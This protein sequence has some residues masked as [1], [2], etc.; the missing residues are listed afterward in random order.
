MKNSDVKIEGIP[1]ESLYDAPLKIE[2]LNLPPEKKVKLTLDGDLKSYG[3]CEAIYKSDKKGKIDLTEQEPVDGD[4]NGIKPMGLFQYRP[5]KKQ[6]EVEDN[7]SDRPFNS[8]D[9]E[10]SL[11]I[12]GDKIAKKEFK[13]VIKAEH[14]ERVEV[15]ENGLQGVLFKPTGDPPYPAV[16]ALGGSSGRCP[17]GIQTKLLTSR[18]YTVLALALFGT[19]DLPDELIGVPLEYYEKAVS[20][21]KSRNNIKNKPIGAMGGSKGGELALLLGSHIEDVQTVIAYSPSGVVFQGIPESF[22]SEFTSSWSY[23]NEP[24]DFVEF[25]FLPVIT[26]DLKRIFLRKP[27]SWEKAYTKAFNNNDNETIKKATIP[28]EKI[29]GPVL[30]VSGG[31]DKMWDAN[32]LSTIAVER[33]KNNNYSHSYKH[34]NFEKAGH[35]LTAPFT[36]V[37]GRDIVNNWKLGGKLQGFSKGDQKS[38]KYVLK[39][40]ERGLKNV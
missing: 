33:L 30:L 26:L 17:T 25:S 9:F 27:I 37:T 16:I 2:I 1:K 18:G 11:E 28:V 35:G 14:V 10:F 15:K 13:R 39:F 3:P 4:Y 32:K 38:W 19:G 40:L 22:F 20:W 23:N 5:E 8:E 7:D 24:I 21:L 12:D 31:E 34:L 36:P 29:G 6:P